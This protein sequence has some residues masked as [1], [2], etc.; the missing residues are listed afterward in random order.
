MR[1]KFLYERGDKVLRVSEKARV[2]AVIKHKSTKPSRQCA[3]ELRK[4]NSTLGMTRWTIATRN[5][6]TILR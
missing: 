1:S 3:E 5:K 4:V 6:D 2:L